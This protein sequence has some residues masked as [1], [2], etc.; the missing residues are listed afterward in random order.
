M[1]PTFVYEGQQILVSS[2]LYPP[3]GTWGLNTQPLTIRLRVSENS[4]QVGCVLP[5]RMNTILQFRSCTP[6]A[7][8]F[9]YSTPVACISGLE[10]LAI[11]KDKPWIFIRGVGKFHISFSGM[12]VCDIDTLN[13]SQVLRNMLGE[14]DPTHP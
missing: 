7:K 9:L 8:K 13:I 3:P 11:V 4:K 5:D 14:K 1:I 6:K 10:T 12:V 2:L